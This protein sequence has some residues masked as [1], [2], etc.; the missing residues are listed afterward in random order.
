MLDIN[1]TDPVL[2]LKV[3]NHLVEL[4]CE[5]PTTLNNT[6]TPKQQ[7]T[8]IEP[9]FR[10][11]METL[12]LD[13]TDDSLQDTPK[14]VAKMYTNETCW[15]LNYA[16]FPKI[17]VVE[18][19]AGYND[20]VIEKNQVI[21]LCVAASTLIETPTG[22]IPISKLKDGD[23]IYTYDEENQSL[24]LAQARNPHCTRKD[25]ELVAVYTDGDTLYCTPEHRILTHN[26]GWVEA[27]M[28]QPG[29]SVVSLY[30][31]ENGNGHV[32][33][34]T[35]NMNIDE[36][37]FVWEQYHNATH[38]TREN[39]YIMVIHH[40]DENPCNNHPD[41]LERMTVSD[42]NRVHQ[43]TEKLAHNENRKQAAAESSGRLEVRAKRSRSLSEYWDSLSDEERRVRTKNMG[44]K[45]N[46]RVISVSKVD[47]TDDV[48]NLEVEGTHNFFGAGMCLH[49]CEHHWVY[50]GTAHN[51]DLGCWI[52]YIPDKKVVGLS[53]LNRVTEFFS[54]RPQIQERLTRQ[55][56]ETLRF[57]LE[58]DDVAVV[59]KAQHFCVLTR[60]I[61]DTTGYTV[62]SS[63]H[64]RFSS[65][66][67][68]RAELMQLVN[69]K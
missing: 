3:H 14:R 33:L 13:L 65:E 46:H 27:Q 59:I 17:T 16:N 1:K 18:N 11:V 58:T 26:R 36:H 68:L 55:I 66:P 40:K 15:G 57:L 2:G 42:H 54:R 67:A 64:G 60:G 32:T 61:E 69:A 52:A 8:R 47:W 43:R 10:K 28:L 24:K 49:N 48:W 5:T 12:R 37:R 62:T 53:K 7:I 45:R 6:F 9:A 25:A 44:G 4:G 41:N 56:A 30:R 29:D 21:S 63:V 31:A 34:R 39:G 38:H 50:F 20:L 23:W 51:P 22:R 19:K 35:H